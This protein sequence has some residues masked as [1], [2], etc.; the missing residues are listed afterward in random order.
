MGRLPALLLHGVQP[1]P[2]T[3]GVEQIG[4]SQG[5]A[6]A[7]KVQIQTSRQT[8]VD[9]NGAAKRSVGVATA[10]ALA[11]NGARCLTGDCSTP[12]VQVS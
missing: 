6:W 1:A 12:V 4:A 8:S 3:L 10:G 2:R 9:E 11:V 5:N 7:G